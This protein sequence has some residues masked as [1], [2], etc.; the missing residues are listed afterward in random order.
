MECLLLLLYTPKRFLC[1]N[2][3]FLASVKELVLLILTTIHLFAHGLKV[4]DPS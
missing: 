1:S 4:P 3:E 2:T